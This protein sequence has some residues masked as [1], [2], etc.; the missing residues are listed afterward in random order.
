MCVPFGDCQYVGPRAP[1]KIVLP[2]VIVAEIE[3][4]M[5]SDDRPE[6]IFLAAHDHV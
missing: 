1:K 3:E 5:R 2:D 4:R 6:S